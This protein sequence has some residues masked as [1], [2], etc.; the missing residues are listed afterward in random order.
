M[1]II[2]PIII[3]L[4]PLISIAQEKTASISTVKGDELLDAP[5]TD[6]SE[7]LY[8]RLP[9]LTVMRNQSG[10]VTFNIR[11]LQTLTDNGIIVLV[12]GFERPIESL[13]VE[14][15]E[16]VSVLKDAAAVA[17]YGYRGVNGILSVRT[18]R[19]SVKGL[20]VNAG[21]EHVFNSALRI[22]QMADSFGYANALNTG[23]TNDGLRPYY[24][25]Y[26]LNAFASH[27]D[28]DIYP[29]VD[30]MGKTLR[31]TGHTD[32]FHVDFNG[33]G[34]KIKYYT[35]LSFQND[36]GLLRKFS[37]T[38][39]PV[40]FRDNRANFR[41]NIDA[42]LTKTTKLSV[43]V[44]ACLDA[45]SRPH[46]ISESDIMSTL[47]T[48]PSA[49]FPVKTKDGIWGGDAVWKDANPV[50]RITSTGYDQTSAR[51]LL[52]DARIE[53]SL[54]AV[55]KGLKASARIGFDS[56][57]EFMETRSTGFEYN[58]DYMVFDKSGEPSGTVR[59]ANGGNKSGDLAFNRY[60][61]WQWKRMNLTADISHHGKA[62]VN[63]Y[64][65]A[66]IYSFQNLSSSGA[67]N[68]FFRH[69]LSLF[70]E[71]AFK[72]ALIVD[73]SL[74]GSGSN[75]N[76]RA[77]R[78]A[79]SPV[80]S[81]AWLVSEEPF[82]ADI[83]GIDLIK[84]RASAGILHNDYVPE[85][86]IV[87]Q[88]FA[89]GS[90]SFVY[91]TGNT[92]VWGAREGFLPTVDPKIERAFK[93]NA[94]LDAAF[95]KSLTFTVDAYFQRRDRIFV[96][97]DPE[98]SSVLGVQAPYVNAGIVY[99]YGTE[100]EIGYN[101]CFNDFRFNAAGIFS[102]SRNWIARTIED[103]GLSENALRTGHPV[104][105]FFGLE[106]LGFFND[107]TEIE[108]HFKQT[109]SAVRPGDVKYRNQNGDG[110]IDENDEV[111]IGYGNVPE[112]S[113]S[114]NIG[115]EYKGIGFDAMFQGVGNYSAYL[116]VPGIY[117]PIVNNANVSEDYLSRCW[118]PDGSNQSPEY[119]RLTATGS[120]NNYRLN[121]IWIKDASFLKLRYCNLYYQFP[122]ALTEKIR[123]KD[124][125]IF[126]RGM[127]LFSIDGIRIM[128]PESIDT[129]MP[130][131]R[132][133]SVG[134][135]AKF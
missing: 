115:F 127:N 133:I 124:L 106:S 5:A 21:Y 130:A 57:A 128:D 110:V 9:G 31:K 126:V 88:N 11:G 116:S 20:E 68:T 23:R 61:N 104:N 100:L 51:T 65:S 75:R 111:P 54:D 15:I 101:R 74:T 37:D 91:G 39:Y 97:E 79:A 95:F 34:D 81:F 76:F 80:L 22:P 77:C 33:G 35:L 56:Y 28:S 44:S 105:Q 60:L 24:N 78:F 45:T 14:E 117:R 87:D 122:A 38:K 62:G 85:T 13:R 72:D 69:N 113:F 63:S 129:G 4:F 8:G 64:K 82:M 55:L 99:S 90:G 18:K 86:N 132:S 59:P 125:K 17:L 94:G 123:I 119:P 131:E 19:G 71:Y 89:S 47:Y 73:F 120:S 29:D 36:N 102:F 96:S 108:E 58:R 3:S 93:Y 40:Q 84:L 46:G 83:K 6:V 107:E 66:L 112:L 41:T 42:S 92:Q 1:K 43:N 103:P 53:Q 10:G 109:F 27:S 121:S 114:L 67:N 32:I 70:L 48:L 52:A 16:S 134:I 118:M 2:I 26:E 7:L 135:S 30:W 49:A 25:Q 98:V 12:D 50:A